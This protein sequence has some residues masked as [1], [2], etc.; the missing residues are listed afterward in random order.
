M[1]G[2]LA[3]LEAVAS[4]ERGVRA[5][6]PSEGHLHGPEQ[7]LLE[8]VGVVLVELLVGVAQGSER[9]PDLVDCLGDV[10][11]ELLA[12]FGADVGHLAQRRRWPGEHHL[13]SG[14]MALQRGIDG[15]IRSAR[16]P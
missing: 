12:G 3:G 5:L 8:L 16:I 7:V 4:S 6:R 1:G 11:Q 15:S 9:D 2:E 14:G 10:V 13:D